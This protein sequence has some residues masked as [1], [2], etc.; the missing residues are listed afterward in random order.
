MG[1]RVHVRTVRA[2]PVDEPAERG[3]RIDYAKQD[4]QELFPTFTRAF[5]WLRWFLA[6]AAEQASLLWRT[7]IRPRLALT[8][9]E[10][11]GARQLGFAM[12]MMFTLGGLGAALT[13]RAE[14]VFWMILGGLV[15]GLTVRVTYQ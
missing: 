2:Q 13:T 6:S 9:K 3:V 10:L 15:I 12:G 14:P 8:V 11:G 4:V 7:S 5:A 1:E